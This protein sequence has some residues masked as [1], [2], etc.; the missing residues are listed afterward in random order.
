MTVIT[1]VDI[2]TSLSGVS[3]FWFQSGIKCLLEIRDFKVLQ[4]L[5]SA[6]R[7]GFFLFF[8]EE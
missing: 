5:T 2:V 8:V 7:D 3:F 1:S 6:L 4:G